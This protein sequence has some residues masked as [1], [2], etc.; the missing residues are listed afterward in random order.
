MKKACK[1]AGV[2]YGQ[3]LEDGIIMRDIRRTVKTGMLDAGVDPVY[4]DLILGHSLKGMDRHY[5]SPSEDTLKGAMAR[6]TDWRDMQFEKK[7]LTKVLT[8]RGELTK[9]YSLFRQLYDGVAISM[10]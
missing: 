5:L 8:M 3:E 2:P 6:F 9:K 10:I 4:R 1:D 7:M